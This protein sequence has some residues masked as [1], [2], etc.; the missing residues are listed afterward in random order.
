MSERRLVTIALALAMT[1]ASSVGAQSPSAAADSALR[2]IRVLDSVMLARAS[3]VD[4]VRRTLGRS[5][6][7][8]ELTSGAL[9]VRTDSELARRVRLA[10]ELV[11]AAVERRRSAVITERVAA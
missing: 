2:H 1:V 7:P 3:A 6:P 11:A 4:S 10:V 9:R 8:F 5:A